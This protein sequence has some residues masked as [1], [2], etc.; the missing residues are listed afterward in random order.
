MNT[1]SPEIQKEAGEAGLEREQHGSR[2]SPAA[3]YKRE[4]D[5][6]GKRRG[7]PLPGKENNSLS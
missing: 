2:S 7:Y 3:R 5:N 4:R 6:K 1:K